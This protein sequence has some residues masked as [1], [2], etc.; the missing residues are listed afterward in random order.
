MQSTFGR[1]KSGAASPHSDSRGL[2]DESD[3]VL[4]LGTSGMTYSEAKYSQGDVRR[5][6]DPWAENNAIVVTKEVTLTVVSQEDQIENVIG[7]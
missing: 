2:T 5:I 6:S 4:E 7:F 1:G 3:L